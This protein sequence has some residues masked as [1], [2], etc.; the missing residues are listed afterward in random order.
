MKEEKTTGGMKEKMNESN[1]TTY[2]NN[3]KSKWKWEMPDTY[4]ILLFVLLLAAAAIH[5]AS[6]HI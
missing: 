5:S 6:G 1:E 4:V 3:R 2:E